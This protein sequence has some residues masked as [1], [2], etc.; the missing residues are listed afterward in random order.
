MVHITNFSK[1]LLD[2]LGIMEDRS[3]KLAD[4]FLEVLDGIFIAGG[5]HCIWPPASKI[6]KLY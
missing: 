4:F 6:F 2:T 1:N 3:K 5:S